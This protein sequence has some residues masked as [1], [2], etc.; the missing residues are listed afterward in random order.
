MYSVKSPYLYFTL[1]E[2]DQYCYLLFHYYVIL[3]YKVKY[4]VMGQVEERMTDS[5]SRL[6]QVSRPPLNEFQRGHTFPAADKVW[7]PQPAP[8]LIWVWGGGGGLRVGA[9]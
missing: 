3:P 6:S 7:A 8:T 2:K 5:L 1:E 4:K 9:Y